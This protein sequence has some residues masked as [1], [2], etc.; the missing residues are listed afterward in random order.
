[1]KRID[2]ILAGQYRGTAVERA[3]D[4]G[5]LAASWESLLGEPW[6]TAARPLRLTNGVLWLG[7]ADS[8][9]AQRLAFDLRRISRRVERFLGYPVEIKSKVI[10]WEVPAAEPEPPKAPLRDDPRVLRAVKDM[11]ADSLRELF[12]DYLGHVAAYQ[13]FTKR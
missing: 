9:W 11:P 8:S 13:Q 12:R 4:A 6:G 7:V 3:L 2:H 5:R 10:A 1:M